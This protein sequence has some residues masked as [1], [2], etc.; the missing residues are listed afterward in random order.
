MNS[1]QLSQLMSGHVRMLGGNTNIMS[2]EYLEYLT[3]FSLTP[4]FERLKDEE[5]LLSAFLD[6]LERVASIVDP[7]D[8]AKAALLYT[9]QADGVQCAFVMKY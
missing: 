4:N 1:C 7:R 8:L 5:V 3:N 9:G 2:R 6:W